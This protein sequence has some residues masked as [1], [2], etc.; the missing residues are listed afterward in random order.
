MMPLDLTTISE[1]WRYLIFDGLGL[2]IKL[3]VTCASIGLVLGVA[4]AMLRLYGFK[5]ISTTVAIYVGLVRSIPLI[6]VIFWFYFLSPYF[7]AWIVGAASPVRIDA[8]TSA[9]ITFALFEACYYCEIV[10]SGIGAISKG[11]RAAGMAMGLSSFQVWRLVI[12]PQALRNI[13]PMLF[14]QAIVLFQ[15]VSL[16]YVLSLTDFVNAA[17]QIAQQKNRLVELYLFVA[18]VYFVV[19]FVATKSVVY[20]QKRYGV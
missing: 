15:D 19:C 17:T 11:Q 1:N 5:W 12:M 13:L 3:T 10:R 2:T 14:L 8:F 18:V 20:L 6:L 16:V 9:L 7:L 4:L